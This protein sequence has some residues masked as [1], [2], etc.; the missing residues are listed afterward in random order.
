MLIPS[1]V[2]MTGTYAGETKLGI[3]AQGQPFT[4]QPQSNGIG[5]NDLPDIFLVC[6]GAS[7]CPTDTNLTCFPGQGPCVSDETAVSHFHSS[8]YI[9][10]LP[11][12]CDSVCL[13]MVPLELSST[14]QNTRNQ[15]KTKT[16]LCLRNKALFQSIANDWCK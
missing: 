15:G 10:P 6:W 11:E 13:T 4:Q 5:T 8:Y 3:R 7:N 14:C 2:P 12:S 1:C 9:N 16:Q